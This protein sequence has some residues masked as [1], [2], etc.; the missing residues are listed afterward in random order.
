MQENYFS[1]LLL[2]FMWPATGLMIASALT[3]VLVKWRSIAGAR[4]RISHLACH[5]CGH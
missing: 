2:W 3:A 1:I 5:L 4:S